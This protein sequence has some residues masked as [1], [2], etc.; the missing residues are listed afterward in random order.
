MIPAGTYE[1]QAV[2]DAVFSMSSKKGTQQV[3]VTMGTTAGTID[4]I[5][6]MSEATLIRTTESLIAMGYDFSDNASVRKNKVSIVVEHEEFEGKL[7]ARVRWVNGLD[8][9]ARY[10]AMSAS[11]ESLVKSRL[12]ATALALRAK[13]GAGVAKASAPPADDV[14][15]DL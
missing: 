5:G 1:S 12:K 11:E 9:A 8:T 3:V 2:S 15:F 6:Y 13:Q 7:R 4:W 14:P 10:T